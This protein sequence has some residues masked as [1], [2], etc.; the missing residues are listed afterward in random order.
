MEEESG[1]GMGMGRTGEGCVMAF[2]GMD[3]YNCER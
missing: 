3:A 2:G 1:R